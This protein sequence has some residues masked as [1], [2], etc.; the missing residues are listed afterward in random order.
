MSDLKKV[1]RGF[2]RKDWL[3]AA[4]EMM[5]EGSLA[6]LTIEK[7]S[8]RLKVAK[9][10]FY[11]HFGNR[12]ALLD[13]LLEYWAEDLTANLTQD[14]NLLSLDPKDRLTEASKAILRFDLARHDLAIRHAAEKEEKIA[15]IVQR[16]T[17][18]RLDFIRRAFS[19]L[20]FEGDDLEMRAMLFVGY[21]TWEHTTFKGVSKERR[22]EL[23]NLQID[24]LTS[25]L[26]T[27][28]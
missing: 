2:S 1:S 23:I 20:G 3:E 6:D 11:W 22:R 26:P 18:A 7:L 24:L 15:E 14:R 28:K 12:Q 8:K 27:E 16:V 19:E 10:G 9:S 4:L 17:E 5:G 13:E 25:G 21:H